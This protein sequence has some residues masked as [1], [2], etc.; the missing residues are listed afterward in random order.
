M[1][2]VHELHV[3]RLSQHKAL[4]TAHV[5]TADDSLAHFMEQARQINECLHAYGIHSATLQPE[6]V[7]ASELEDRKSAGLSGR[8]DGKDA[9]AV[10]SEGTTSHSAGVQ[11][12]VA[13]K[14][15][16]VRKRVLS[17]VNLSRCRMACGTVCESLACCAK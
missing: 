7:S 9:S 12:G 14:P 11:V 8:W 10:G 2:A 17:H 16:Q 15:A 3:W 4:A 1:L 13:A 6:L 5:L